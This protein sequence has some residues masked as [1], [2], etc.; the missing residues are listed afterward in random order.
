MARQLKTIT[1]GE[2]KD[3]LDGYDEDTPV[4]FSADYGDYHHTPQALP[5]KG[6]AEDVT[7][8]ETGYSNSGF[9]VV[10]E[11]DEEIDYDE[12]EQFLLIR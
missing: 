4:I 10:T 6:E 3:L 2:L 9:A 1:V 8:T 5:L 12:D 11:E 7:V